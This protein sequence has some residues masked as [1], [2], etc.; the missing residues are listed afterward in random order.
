[1]KDGISLPKDTKINDTIEICFNMKGKV[2]MI[3]KDRLYLYDK[4]IEDQKKKREQKDRLIFAVVILMV[5][6]AFIIFIDLAE[7]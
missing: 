1:M 3:I 4:T 5:L 7:N 2:E 6:V